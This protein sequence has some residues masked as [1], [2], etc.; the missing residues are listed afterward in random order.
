M[1]EPREA[2]IESRGDLVVVRLIG[3]PGRSGY[4]AFKGAVEKAGARYNEGAKEYAGPIGAA[5]VIVSAL[6]RE[7]FALDVAQDV[8][9][10]VR[11]EDRRGRDLL[12]GVD[13]RVERLAE[14]G[15]ELKPWQ[16]EAVRFMA[17]RRRVLNH[18]DMGLGKTIEALVAAPYGVPVLICCP[19]AAIGVWEAE[20]GAWRPDL[21]PVVTSSTVIAS[22]RDSFRWPGLGEAVIVSSAS[23]PGELVKHGK[24]TRAKLPEHLAKSVPD[25][26]LVLFD[27][28]HEYKDTK[29]GRTKRARTIARAILKAGG[30]AWAL[31]GTPL[32]NNPQELWNVLD[33]VRLAETAYGSFP[34]F[35]ALCKGRRVRVGRGVMWKWGKEPSPLVPELLRRV[36]IG[37]LKEDWLDGEV[38][39]RDLVTDVG[40]EAVALADEVVGMLRE[41]GVDIDNVADVLDAMRKAKIPFELLSRV[42]QALAVGKLPA[43]VVAVDYLEHELG[44]PVLFF[45]DH[46]APIEAM[47]KRPGWGS[48]TGADS[49]ASKKAKEVA[50]QRGDIRNLA[51]SV[52]AAG[53]ALTLTRAN[54]VVLNDGPW[55]PELVRQAVDRAN[56][57]GQERWPVQV[58]RIRARH[59]LEARIF[60]TLDRKTALVAATT[61]AAA[62]RPG[63]GE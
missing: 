2:R 62:R 5:R 11:S 3:W 28:A 49:A 9:D 57:L 55:T 38:V 60:E 13:I 35:T 59:Q 18:D 8:Q 42:R 25:G 29:A 45:S 4:S 36:A 24:G 54:Q 30:S 44:E 14:R 56:R 48:I 22:A 16:P 53:V 27:E 61:R 58:T 6:H 37:R 1:D 51:L 33:L 46:R 40:A 7:G 34:R 26:A 63:G 19:S 21:R 12:E 50:F 20:L 52:K 10:F 43:S 31:T 32:L 41:A 17:T 23:L 39:V 15:R 47:A